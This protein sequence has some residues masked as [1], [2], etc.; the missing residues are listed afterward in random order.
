MQH[1]DSVIIQ[2]TNFPFR[3]KPKSSNIPEESLHFDT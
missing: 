3:G 1:V 2:R